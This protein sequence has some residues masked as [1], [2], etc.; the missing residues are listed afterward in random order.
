[1]HLRTASTLL[2]FGWLAAAVTT[3]VVWARSREKSAEAL[4]PEGVAV[5][6][7]ITY[8]TV[9]GRPLALDLYLPDSPISTHR[10]ALL[11]I[12]GG[13]W[14]GGSRRDYGAQLARL[15]TRGFVV[16][17]I[18]YRLARPGAPSWDGSLD[19]VAT[20]V[21]WLREHAVRYAID[22]DRI[23]AIGTSAGGL[24]AAHLALGPP[25]KDGDRS[26]PRV[27]ASICLSTPYELVAL[28]DGRELPHEPALEFVGYHD[29][30]YYRRLADASPIYHVTPGSH[31][32]LL[33]HGTD[34]IWVPIE[35]ARQMHVKL[36]KAG[37]PSRILAIDDARHGF[38]L[39]V[40]APNPRDLLPE[41]LEF[42]EVVWRRSNPPAG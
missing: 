35:Q 41:I 34:D 22:P 21:D 23:A 15:V 33:I 20:A 27:D 30:L 5:I 36:E 14:V 7:N 39:R 2:A 40:G 13:S 17:A 25:K 29:E 18:D 1:M 24:L 10:P 11:A 31:P 12:H 9:E 3:A 32:L 19:D 28:V 37:V 8:R 4:I 38:E 6:R 42:L 26:G 16:A